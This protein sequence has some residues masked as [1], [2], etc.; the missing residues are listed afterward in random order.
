MNNEQIKLLNRMKQL[1]RTNKK[2]FKIRK[3]R[4]YLEDLKEIG[5]TI[6]DAWKQILTL[7]TNFYFI[8]NK[9][10]YNQSQNTLTFK[11]TINKKSVYIKLE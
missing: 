11:K 7:N 6:E 8:D 3:D 2:K 1:I 4:D 5:I 9:P 10:F